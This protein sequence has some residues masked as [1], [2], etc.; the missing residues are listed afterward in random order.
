MSGVKTSVSSSAGYVVP[1]PAAAVVLSMNES[2]WDLP[3]DVKVEIASR[4]LEV[5]WQRYPEVDEPSLLRRLAEY[6]GHVPEGI[7]LG[8]G[9]DEL[10]QAVLYAVCA[11]GDTML[12]VRPE[13]AMYRQAASLVGIK[14]VEVPLDGDM[15]FDIE[16]IVAASRSAK[17]VFLSSPNNPA[18]TLLA[19]REVETILENT[20]AVVV[21]DEAY[22]EFSRHT[23]RPLL[24]KYG[25]LVILRT[26]SKAFRLAGARLGYL[27][28]RPEMVGELRKSRL[29]YSV[30]IFQQTAAEALLE[31]RE[32]IE[33]GAGRIIA[34]RERVFKELAALKNFRPFPSGGNYIF[35]R[36]G[37]LK[38]REIFNRLLEGG[39]AVRAFNA[40]GL[41]DKVRLTIGAPEEND[42]VLGLLGGLDMET[43]S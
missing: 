9:S 37:V 31:Q 24:E 10:I 17:A 1:G 5:E 8:N 20:E 18:G 12:T 25:N 13:F 30:G 27:L 19:L 42:A 11:S 32:M 16:G 6:T 43:G 2:P 21:I 29:P 28:A 14:T 4:L 7:L 40:P 39:V 34:E 38:G 35:I 41:E 33:A 22:F 23:C 15:A 26:F 3:R 36:S